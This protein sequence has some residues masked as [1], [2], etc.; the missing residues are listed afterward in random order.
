MKFFVKQSRQEKLIA[1]GLLKKLNE[2]RSIGAHRSPHLYKFEK[3]AYD[4]ALK[5]GVVLN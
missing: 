4:K 3:A 5:E 1:L 2:K